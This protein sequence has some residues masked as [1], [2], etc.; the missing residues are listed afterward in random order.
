MEME[1]NN[2]MKSALN[3]QLGEKSQVLKEQQQSASDSGSESDSDY[4]VLSCHY[5]V[6]PCLFLSKSFSLARCFL[7]TFEKDTSMLAKEFATRPLCVN[8]SF[9]LLHYP[10]AGHCNHAAEVASVS[11]ESFRLLDVLNY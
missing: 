9:F 8:W 7:E 5:T 6:R 1:E 11:P 4:E 10:V 2:K 3:S